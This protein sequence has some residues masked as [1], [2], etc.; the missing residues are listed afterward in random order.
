MH[1]RDHIQRITYGEA[2]IIAAGRDDP[3]VAWHRAEP[4]IFQPLSMEIKKLLSINYLYGSNCEHFL[5]SLDQASLEL[6][7][8]T[9]LLVQLA[10][11]DHIH[12]PTSSSVFFGFLLF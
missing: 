7:H 12:G 10:C 11:L 3:R 8:S 5:H 2:G 1:K 9:C 4:V 6:F